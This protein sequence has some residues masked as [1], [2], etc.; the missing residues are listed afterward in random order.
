MRDFT[1]YQCACGHKGAVVVSDNDQPYSRIWEQ[2][3]LRDLEGSL[4]SRSAQDADRRS[5]AR[6]LSLQG[7][8]N[9]A[10]MGVHHREQID[11]WTG[12]GRVHRS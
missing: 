10:W 7:R 11:S 8:K 9:L 6:T 4:R 3:S 12:D 1:W 2:T 5:R